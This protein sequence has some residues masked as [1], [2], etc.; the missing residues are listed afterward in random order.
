MTKIL[1]SLLAIIVTWP[2]VA[3]AA[4]P[5]EHL[6][7]LAPLVGKTWRGEFAGSTPEQPMVDVQR[8]EWA[9]GG[10]AIKIV[11][12]LN[13]GAYGGESIVL[14]DTE[15]ER[16]IYFYF[17]TQGFYTTGTM[18]AEDGFFVTHEEV[19]GA[20]GGVTAVRS[21][22]R[23]LSDGQIEVRTEFLRNGAWGPGREVIYV[24]DPTAELILPSV[25]LPATED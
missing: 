4:R 21:T 1:A 20:A 16:L 2:A 14:W 3:D 7:P 6:L 15:H 12:S 10:Q 9:L 19:S 5:N 18:A 8:W 17:T 23:I 25:E 24:E 13:D 22:S 11:H